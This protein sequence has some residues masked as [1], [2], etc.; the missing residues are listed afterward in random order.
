MKTTGAL[1]KKSNEAP[2]KKF[3]YYK[4]SFINFRS[5]LKK[6]LINFFILSLNKVHHNISS[7][8]FGEY[9]LK[10]LFIKPMQLSAMFFTI[11][12]GHDLHSLASVFFM[13]SSDGYSPFNFISSF[14]HY[15]FTHD[16][17]VSIGLK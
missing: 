8:I 1:K 4:K 12:G 7:S 2:A 6:N 9:S 16:Q 15:Y 11:N 13:N 14:L 10:Y 3:N 5:L 17:T